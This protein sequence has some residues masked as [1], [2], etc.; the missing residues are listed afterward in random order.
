MNPGEGI[1]ANDSNSFNF[2]RVCFWN[3]SLFLLPHMDVDDD[4]DDTMGEAKRPTHSLALSYHS[5]LIIF[6]S[7]LADI[8][9]DHEDRCIPGPSLVFHST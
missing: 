7:L 5:I 1:L 8:E 3:S 2:G 4:G 6:H 9:V